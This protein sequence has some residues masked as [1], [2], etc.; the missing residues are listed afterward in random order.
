MYEVTHTIGTSKNCSSVIKIAIGRSWCLH[1]DPIYQE[2][3]TSIEKNCLVIVK[4]T[5]RVNEG[6]LI[7]VGERECSRFGLLFAPEACES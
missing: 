1:L 6:A 5:S 4:D 2:D 3:C 7:V